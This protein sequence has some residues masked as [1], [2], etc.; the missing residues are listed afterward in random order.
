MGYGKCGWVMAKG[1]GTKDM[2]RCAS[3]RPENLGQMYIH[4]DCSENAPSVPGFRPGI[5]GLS[6][7]APGFPRVLW[8]RNYLQGAILGSGGKT[9]GRGSD[10]MY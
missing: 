4:A 10:V 7:S 5:P 8:L 1:K 9:K 3:F 6:D 2:T